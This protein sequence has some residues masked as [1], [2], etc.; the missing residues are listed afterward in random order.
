ML[1]SC[2]GLYISSFVYIDLLKSKI[3]NSLHILL[4]T[5]TLF[6]YITTVKNIL[7]VCFIFSE[8]LLYLIILELQEK[9]EEAL[10]VL[11]GP[12]GGKLICLEFILKIPSVFFLPPHIFFSRLLLVEDELHLPRHLTYSNTVLFK[13]SYL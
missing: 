7:N 8:I 11:E 10:K 1:R 3:I 5:V 4:W 9:W 6:K 13:H 2:F 12:L